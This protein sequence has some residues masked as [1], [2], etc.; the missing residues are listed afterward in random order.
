MLIEL[1]YNG[2]MLIKLTLLGKNYGMISPQ[3]ASI[4]N[5]LEITIRFK[6]V[7]LNDYF[8]YQP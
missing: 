8:L 6:C 4:D 5:N 2:N 7:D 3:K 1:T